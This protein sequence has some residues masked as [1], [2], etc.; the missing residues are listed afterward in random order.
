MNN[1]QQTNPPAQQSPAPANL[2]SWTCPLP[3][4]DYPTVVMGHGGGGKLSADLIKHL[5][6]PAFE[7]PTLAQMGDAAVVTPGGANHPGIAISTDSFTV[8]PLFFP[9]GDIGKLAIH[10]TLNDVAMVGARPLFLSAG[11]ILEEGLPLDVLGRIAESMAD[12]CQEA[13]ATII[14]GDTKVVD[15]GHGDGVFINTT[16]FGIVPPGVEI[17][18]DRARPGD[19]VLVSGDIGVHGIAILSVR[20]GLAFETV[21]ESDTAS[22]HGL[23]AEMLGVTPE[24]HCLRDPT[25]GGMA[26]ALNEIAAASG[27]GIELDETSVPVPAAVRA[28]CEML[29]LDPFYIANEG[30]LVAI[31]PAEHVEAVLARMQSHPLG[32]QAAVVGRVTESHPGIVVARTGI[33]GRRVVDMLVGEQL[34]RIC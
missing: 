2:D 17:R 20:E 32:R 12:A 10:G 34:P 18:A 22:L 21:V 26:A 8:T 11:F 24:I 9:G 19:L 6:F 13:G 27:V 5:F 15:K 3:L 33:G 30:K 23:V 31:L 4:R 25:R 29:G 14:T 1:T 7:N 28:A 16:G